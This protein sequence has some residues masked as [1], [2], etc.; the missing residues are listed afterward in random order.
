MAALFS[1]IGTSTTGV[2]EIY[3]LISFSN[4]SYYCLTHYAYMQIVSFAIITIIILA[5][6][7]IECYISEKEN[8]TSML[9]G[10]INL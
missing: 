7:C 6:L 9:F 3:G 4:N 2:D 5:M 10:M 1:E 8:D